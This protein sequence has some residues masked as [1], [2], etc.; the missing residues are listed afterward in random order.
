MN[1]IAPGP[2]ETPLIARLHTA[3]RQKWTEP[4]AAR[5]RYGTAEE[6]AAAIA[7]LLSPDASYI[8]GQTLAVDG[9]P[10]C[11][12]A[13]SATVDFLCAACKRRPK[14]KEPLVWSLGET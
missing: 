2:I 7:F 10:S 1:C 11:R 6:V 12:L 14:A 5:R 3:D 8:N 4:H 13:S 9:E